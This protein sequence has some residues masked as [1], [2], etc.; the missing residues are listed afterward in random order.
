MN[1]GTPVQSKQKHSDITSK[2]DNQH[3]ITSNH[4][5]CEAQVTNKTKSK[6]RKWK[7]VEVLGTGRYGTVS[8]WKNK[9]T[10]ERVA[11]KERNKQ[12]ND[13]MMVHWRREVEIVQTLQHENVVKAVKV[14]ELLEHSEDGEVLKLPLQYC[15][16]GDLR[17]VLRRPEN[18]CGLQEYDVR[19][20]VKQ[21]AAAIEHL[22]N[23]RI[24]HRDIKPEN[25][26]LHYKDNLKVVYKLT[27]FGY[28]VRWDEDPE[29]RELV[30]TIQYLAPEMHGKKEYSH[31]VDYWSFGTVVFEAIAGHRPFALLSPS[32]TDWLSIVSKKQSDHICAIKKPAGG[33]EYSNE[34]PAPNNLS[35]Y[36][37]INME[38]WLM[39]MLLLEPLLRGGPLQEDNRIHCFSALDDILEVKIVNIYSIHDNKFL[40]YPMLGDVDNLCKLQEE[41][42][43][44]CGITANDQL[45]LLPNGSSPEES[46]WIKKCSS[47][48]GPQDL[49]VSVFATSHEVSEWNASDLI[50]RITPPVIQGIDSSL[51]VPYS[52]LRSIYRH[53]VYFCHQLV[54]HQTRLEEGYKAIIHHVLE[55]NL[56]LSKQTFLLMASFHKFLGKVDFF[57]ESLELDVD[58]YLDQCATGI[59]SDKIFDSWKQS[60]ED[61]D[62]LDIFCQEN[63]MHDIEKRASRLQD[64]ITEKL[65]PQNNS[66]KEQLTSIEIE[67]LKNEA[68]K[69]YLNVLQTPKDQRDKS[70]NCSEMFG[71]VY[72]ST[73]AWQKFH[74]NISGHIS[75]ALTLR[76]EILSLLKKM[77]DTEKSLERDGQKL[78]EMHRQRQ[79]DVWALLK[80]QSQ[81]V[82]AVT[83]LNTEK[84]ANMKLVVQV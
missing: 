68:Q 66:K 82:S 70:F 69:L 32:Y 52:Q 45:L 17:K 84:P 43:K 6:S 3:D 75:D 20:L 26:T 10:G 25:I 38:R 29:S 12:V 16:G 40:S 53:R 23:K 63:F 59:E 61:F 22:H 49:F 79:K 73:T 80:L 13:K 64:R 78:S 5:N 21:L 56:S 60:K 72:K 47:K 42:A 54:K 48:P 4:G 18:C 14:A 1:H 35:E 19:E 8:L 62:R 55:L 46:N 74:K 15:N 41:V 36:M 33:L 58:N 44:H 71:I 51:Q 2:Q 9:E 76:L 77:S 24:M 50:H 27:D 57:K 37:K 39:W 28:A 67:N 81:V 11:L 83:N 31:A 30:G 65:N 7:M 34:L